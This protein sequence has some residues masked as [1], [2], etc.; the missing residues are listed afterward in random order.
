M[1]ETAPHGWRGPQSGRGALA[2]TRVVAG[3]GAEQT[4]PTTN[5]TRLAWA[6]CL[7]RTRLPSTTHRK[8]NTLVAG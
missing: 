3:N 6:Q 8:S 4:Q 2:W 5:T 1:E 7:W